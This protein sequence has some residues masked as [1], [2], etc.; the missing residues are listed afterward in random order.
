[1]TKRLCLPVLLL[2]TMA[3]S[4][5]FF[6]QPLTDRPSKDL[7]TWLLGVWQT[8]DEKGKTHQATLTPLTGSRYA[9]R[10]EILGSTKKETKTWVFEGWISRVGSSVFLNLKCLDSAGQVPPDAF[11]FLHY[12]VVAQNTVVTRALQLGSAQNATSMEIRKEIRQ[13]LKDKT[14]Y[15]GSAVTVWTR[16]SEVYWDADSFAT[17]PLQPL[18]FPAQ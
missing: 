17:Q 13:K 5:C 10:Y 14:L 9:V 11:V 2:F 1:M 8:K 6:D 4:G 16:I 7:N 18:R 15:D 12:Q 3:L